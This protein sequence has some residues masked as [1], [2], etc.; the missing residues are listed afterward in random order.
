MA[1]EKFSTP[2][3]ISMALEKFST[4]LRIS[5]ALRIFSF[6]FL[7]NFF[8]SS[9]C[10]TFFKSPVLLETFYEHVNIKLPM[11]VFNELLLF[12]MLRLF[13]RKTQPIRLGR[14]ART[15]AK[16][17]IDLSNHDHCGGILCEKPLPKK[18]IM[19]ILWI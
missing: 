8:K 9:F 4:P 3:R 14:W 12:I 11:L 2:L 16:R 15:N 17:K 13:S 7:P 1:L 10:R 5:M 6:F 19:I 18:M